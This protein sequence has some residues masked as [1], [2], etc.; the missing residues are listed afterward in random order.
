MQDRHDMN[1]RYTPAGE[2]F[3]LFPEIAPYRTGRLKVSP[4]HQLY[5]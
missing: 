5:F 4:L 1:E 2:P 3:S